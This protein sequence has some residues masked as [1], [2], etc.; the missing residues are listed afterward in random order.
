[1]SQIWGCECADARSHPQIWG[2]TQNF[3]QILTSEEIHRIF[4]KSRGD[5]PGILDEPSFFTSQPL[6]QPI[7][8]G[9]IL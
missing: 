5:T 2:T 8:M 1:M 7:R 3:T 4:G 9:M 6:L